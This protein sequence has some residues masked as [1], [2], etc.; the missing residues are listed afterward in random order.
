MCHRTEP[1]I[2]SAKLRLFLL[3]LSSPISRVTLVG[4]L[5]ASRSVLQ[6]DQLSLSLFSEWHRQ[7]QSARLIHDLNDIAVLLYNRQVIPI[8]NNLHKDVCH[9][10]GS[11]LRSINIGK[12][13]ALRI[14]DPFALVIEEETV[15]RHDGRNISH[16][17]R[18]G[19][20]LIGVISGEAHTS[21]S[22][23]AGVEY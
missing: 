1:A 14:P 9:P 10:T 18:T 22:R 16:E 23:L 6:T 2:A 5:S 19:N 20:L 17:A 15:T 3:R 21:H 4:L 7:E 8:R 12:A 11:T 13:Q